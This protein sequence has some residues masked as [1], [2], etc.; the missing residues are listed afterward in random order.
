MT[1]R[2]RPCNVLIAVPFIAMLLIASGLVFSGCTGASLNKKAAGKGADDVIYQVTEKE[3]LDLSGWAVNQVFPEMK[4]FR[5]KKPRVG[6]FIHE[7]N[8]PG[9]YRIA[10]FKETSYFYELDMV[11]VQGSSERG[12]NVVGYTYAVKGDGDLKHGPEK[13]ALLEKKMFEAFDQ[14]GRAISVAA[15]KPIKR[16]GPPK[17]SKEKPS[18]TPSAVPSAGASKPPALPPVAAP[19][20]EPPMVKEA[21]S[22][23]GSAEKLPESDEAVFIKL[24]KLKELRDQGI[25]TE[26]E[27]QTKKKELLDRI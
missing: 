21:P 15:V 3:A 25:I 2:R 9:H 18:G 20:P 6:Y 10:R 4:V 12:D 14:S 5:L 17:L 24:K 13:L 26:E 11:K 16:T 19:A 8:K 1:D 22:S 27:F 23:S 7:V